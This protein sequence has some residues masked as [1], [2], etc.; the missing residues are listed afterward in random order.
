MGQLERWL[1]L[2]VSIVVAC[3]GTYSFLVSANAKEFI[4]RTQATGDQQKTNCFSHSYFNVGSQCL[5]QRRCSTLLQKLRSC[6]RSLVDMEH[7]ATVH[8]SHDTATAPSSSF[9]RDTS[10][11]EE[12][13]PVLTQYQD[14]WLDRSLQKFITV[15]IREAL[16]EAD[17]LPV[18][19]P[20][21]R[22]LDADSATPVYDEFI[23]VAIELS[24]RPGWQT[25]LITLGLLRGVFPSWFPGAFRT[26]LSLFPM[27]FDA[28]HAAVSTVLTT[29]WLVGPSNVCDVEPEILD[30]TTRRGWGNEPSGWVPGFALGGRWRKELGAGQGVKI[31]KCRVLEMTGCAS[32]CANVCKGP[33]Q[34]FF[35]EDVGLPLTMIPDF[36]TM[37]CQFVFGASP[38]ELSQDPAFQQPCLSQC[39]A[40]AAAQVRAGKAR[41]QLAAAAAVDC[42][43]SRCVGL[44]HSVSGG[45]EPD[46]EATHAER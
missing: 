13:T 3:D 35:T 33:T 45:S 36:E 16:A 44:E 34:A 7:T 20:G 1:L 5:R 46:S 29:G 17:E 19:E 10:P 40:G 12:P 8:P 21:A 26:F 32:V 31:D 39:Q 18:E 24:R 38:P 43:E 28:R 27:W 11:P 23:D 2:A 4:P 37:G 25:Q 22:T 6:D 42:E 14:S 9:Q 15:K 30:E 41:A